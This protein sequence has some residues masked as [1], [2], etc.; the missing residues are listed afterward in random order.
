MNG[1]SILGR[2]RL[3]PMQFKMH[4]FR[5]LETPLQLILIREILVGVPKKAH[6]KINVSRL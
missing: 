1:A 2:R 4:T 6:S 5:H 3:H